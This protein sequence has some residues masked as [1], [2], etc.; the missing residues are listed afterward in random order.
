MSVASRDPTDRDMP[1]DEG[2]AAHAHGS[3]FGR[4]KGHK[5]RIHQ[6]DLIAHLLP[7]LALDIGSPAPADL[8]DLFDDG[9]ETIRLEIGFGGG[10]H[11]I[12][13]AQAFPDIGFIGCEP[14]VNGMAKILTQIE[15][16]N[17]KNI[18]L[19][20]GDAAE[21]VAWAPRQS[22]ARIDLIHPDPWPKRRHWKRRFVQDATVAAMAR[23]LKPQG[24][25]RFVSDI[26]D[27]CAWT[28]A[29][30]LRSPDFFWLAERAADWHLPWPGYTMTRYGRKA[31][32]EGRKA[33]Y[34]RF[35]RV[36]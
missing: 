32:R 9:I 3:F 4:R 30:L 1:S 28:L 27:Y 21:L 26:D 34:L 2:A 24:E 10:E 6:A 8:S 25:F 23:I 5:L 22:M 33:A 19:Y 13:E 14:Y 7:Q 18:R 35:R 20:A 31:E 15:S 17:V 11:L 36:G 29:H 16:V 12:A